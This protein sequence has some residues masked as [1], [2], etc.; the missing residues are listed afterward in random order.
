[1]RCGLV[2]WLGGDGDTM[3]SMSRSKMA[4]ED[5]CL[6]KAL[7]GLHAIVADLH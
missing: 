5:E 4:D 7:A 1:M 6:H 2:G 3:G